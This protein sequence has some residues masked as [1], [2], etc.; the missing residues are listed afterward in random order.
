MSSFKQGK[1]HGLNVTISNE[2]VVINLFVNG[3]KQSSFAFDSSFAELQG[4]YR[5]VGT[6]L[7]HLSTDHFNPAVENPQAANFREP[8]PV[9]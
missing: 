9:P 7:N 1:F 8:E 4:L 2:K 5:R 3:E 6:A